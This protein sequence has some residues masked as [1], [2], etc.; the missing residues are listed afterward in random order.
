M[1][2]GGLRKLDVLTKRAGILRRLAAEPAH[3]RDL[4]DE[5]DQSRRTISRALNDLEDVDLVERGDDGF[6]A[7]AAGRLALDRLDTFRSN[8]DDIV[9]AEAVLDPLPADTPIETT[10]VA[11]GEA[12][13]VDESLPHRPLERF[14]DALAD[15]RQYRAVLP[16]LEDPRHFRLLYEHVVTD[17]RPAELVV[18]PDLLAALRSEFPRG[19]AAM[20]EAE[21]FDLFGGAVPPFAVALVETGPEET[22]A[23]TVFV[24]VFTEKGGVHGVV[25]N[26][27]R[28]AR[29]WAET[30]YAGQRD[31]ADDR[32]D[33]LIPDPDGGVEAVDADGGIARTALGRSMSVALERA[34]FVRLGQEYFREE[35]VADP[36]T[37]WRA[38]L[39]IPEVHTGYAVER[40][41]SDDQ[42]GTEHAELTGALLADL[43]GGTDCLVVGPPGSGKSTVCKRVACAWYDADRGPVLYREGGRG[44]PFGSVEDLLVTADA[45]EDHTLVVVEDAVRPETDAVFDAIDRLGDRDDVSF[46]LDARTNEWRDPPGEP[47]D[48]PALRVHHM[49]QFED[50][51]A[52]RLVE[53]FERTVG[54]AVDIP[55]E[56]LWA[57]V[58]DAA[59]T[60]AAAPNEVL[61][62][63]HRLATYA[64]PLT[65]EQTSLEEAVAAVYDDLADDEIAL[66]VCVLAN[67]LNAAGI[68]VTAGELYAVADPE[69]FAAVDRALE[70]LEGRVLF[71]R[72]D[73]TYRTVHESWSATFLEHLLDSEGRTAAAER[74]GD[75]VSALLALADAPGERDA[76]RRH[77]DGQWLLTPLADDPVAWADGTVETVYAMGREWPKLG[78]LFGDGEH[79][80][81]TLPACC[82]EWVVDQRP[83]WLGQ[84][85]LDGGYYDRAERAYERL[86]RDDPESAVERLIGLAAVARLQGDY[87]DTVAYAEEGLALIEDGDRPVA[88]AQLQMERGTASSHLGEF[89]AAESDLRAA[90]DTFEAV[91]ERQ[92]RAK[93]LH[94]IGLS[95]KQQGEFDQARE[96]ERRSLERYR[97]LDD[98]TGEADGLLSLGE[99]LRP[100]GEYDQARRLNEQALEIYQRLGDRQGE[101]KSFNNLGIV[102][103]IQGD[104]DRAYDYFDRSL[105]AKQRLGDS[106]G[107][108]HTRHNLGNVARRLG[109]YDRA[110]EHFRRSLEIKERLGDSRG[111]VTT[112][113]NLGELARQQG[114]YDQAREYHERSLALSRELGYQ[115]GEAENRSNLGE[116]ARIRGEYEQAREHLDRALDIATAVSRPDDLLQTRRR[117]GKLAHAQGDHSRA[118]EQFEKALDAAGDDGDLFEQMRTRLA[119]AR[120]AFDRDDPDLA[121]ERAES[122]RE[123]FAE[124]GSSP[125]VARSRRLLGRVVAE[126]DNP[127]AA[128]EH[129][130]AAL[131]TFE[132][133]GAP[134][135]ALDALQQLV[136]TCRDEGDEEGARE[137]LGRAEDLL[138]DAPDLV[139][140]QHRAWIERNRAELDGD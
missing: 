107:E 91:D 139:A 94:R 34:G 97:E 35:P 7:T 5:L 58:R 52:E 90:L 29:R 89:D 102:A 24:V 19:M 69:G 100:L 77:L 111:R 109:R 32:T 110:R 61:L 49:P 96:Y 14:Y 72:E 10:A 115:P 1:D 83:V 67:V 22:E 101:S 46:L 93:T 123:T 117:L 79:D 25:K 43:E 13:L 105:E 33:D 108:A 42:S 6:A 112:L 121:R 128:R 113:I 119:R 86:S 81:V 2:G 44:R 114:A 30:L 53:H 40:T 16:A 73:D 131:D 71:P 125:W 103:A 51:D 92:Q 133:V 88:R 45:A 98:R 17:G 15:A 36:T 20:A 95:K 138:A 120:L 54:T 50:G 41:L 26:D 136:E 106:K 134:Q 39:T 31:G 8:L 23:T 68:E 62:L 137:W 47:T 130:E 11:G 63:L 12:L 78:P 99:V 9:A 104:Y 118:G 66:D 18:A 21:A 38:G 80:S 37:A 48:V 27:G 60:E 59:A 85:L 122:A 140:D 74:F 75:C 4:V 129:W 84:L 57:D 124:I 132:E 126:S 135:D 65:D 70:Y 55:V 28:T 76:I 82:S 127:G 3:K 64:D 116:L 87:D 56:R